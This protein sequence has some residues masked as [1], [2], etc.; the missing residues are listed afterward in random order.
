MNGCLLIEGD[1]II[2]FNFERVEVKPAFRCAP[3]FTLKNDKLYI[4]GGKE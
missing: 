4:A 1:K 2:Q 3:G